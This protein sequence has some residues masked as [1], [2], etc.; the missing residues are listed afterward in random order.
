VNDREILHRLGQNIRAARNQAGITQECLAELVG[1]HWKTISAIER[2]LFP[3]GVTSFVLIVQH[4]QV[5]ADSLLRG[6]ERP[7]Q[8]RAAAIRR[9]LARRRR[10]KSS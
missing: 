9:A 2:G 3:V 10:P 6:I 8:R 7:D 1:L 4:L 5:S